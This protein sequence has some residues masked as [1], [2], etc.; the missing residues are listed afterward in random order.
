MEVGVDKENINEECLRSE[1]KNVKW[2]HDLKGQWYAS[3]DACNQHLDAEELC[4]VIFW[5]EGK[6]AFLQRKLD[7]LSAEVACAIRTYL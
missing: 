3:C 4:R 2:V 7:T 6:I 1:H 5:K